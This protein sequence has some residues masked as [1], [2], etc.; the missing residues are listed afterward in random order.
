MS[1]T[2]SLYWSHNEQLSFYLKIIKKFMFIKV[3]RRV[4]LAINVKGKV[5]PVLFFD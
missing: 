2:E 3:I 5:V 1:P 4:L